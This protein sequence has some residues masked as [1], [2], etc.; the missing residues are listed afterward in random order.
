IGHPTGREI[1]DRE[2]ADLDMEVIL[3]AAAKSGVAMEISASPYRLD[4]DDNHARRASELGVLIS[5]NTDA[6]AEEDLDMLHY[7]VAIARRAS[8]TKDNVINTWST[9]K[10][11]DWLKN[12]GK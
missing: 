9:K 4:L 10:L 12:R 6:H 11:L 5:I 7:G 1:P 2:G 8:L 3:K